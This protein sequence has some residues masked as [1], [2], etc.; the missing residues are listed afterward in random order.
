MKSS[1]YCECYTL[2]KLVLDQLLQNYEK[3]SQYLVKEGQKRYYDT[4]VLMSEDL[5]EQLYMTT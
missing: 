1:F 3:D 5:K 4:E 2:E